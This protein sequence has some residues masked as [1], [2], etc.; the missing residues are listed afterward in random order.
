MYL[1]CSLTR[2]NKHFSVLVIMNTLWSHCDPWLDPCLISPN[3]DHFKDHFYLNIFR[4][5][6][7]REWIFFLWALVS[8]MN[9]LS[10]LTSKFVVSICACLIYGLSLLETNSFSCDVVLGPQDGAQKPTKHSRYRSTLN[11]C[12]TL[13]VNLR[14]NYD[15]RNVN[16]DLNWLH[17]GL[18]EC[19][20]NRTI[21]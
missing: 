11:A 10:Y 20:E 16:L 1:N 13:K 19:A 21:W 4:E 15:V 17:I 8:S 14:Q 18:E 6:K 7:E 5:K 9:H 2:N 3:P 12:I